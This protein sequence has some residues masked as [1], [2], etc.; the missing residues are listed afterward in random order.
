MVLLYESHTKESMQVDAFDFIAMSLLSKIGSLHPLHDPTSPFSHTPLHKWA[1]FV[2]EGQN[3]ALHRKQQ[4]GGVEN[5]AHVC[6]AIPP[7]S[8]AQFGHGV[9]DMVSHVVTLR[10]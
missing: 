3:P 7:Q 1:E 4:Q 6:V 2:S 10:E 9:T 8:T 5:G